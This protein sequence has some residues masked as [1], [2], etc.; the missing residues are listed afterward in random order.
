ME[1]IFGGNFPYNFICV[2]LMVVPQVVDMCKIRSCQLV[3]ILSIKVISATFAPLDF[4]IFL[5]PTC[6][7]EVLEAGCDGRGDEN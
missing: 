5:W 3:G 2:R 1:R 7:W 4:S 6:H